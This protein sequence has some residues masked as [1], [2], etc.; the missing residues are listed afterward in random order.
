[1]QKTKLNA[2]QL[3]ELN[4]VLSHNLPCNMVF[5]KHTKKEWKEFFNSVKKFI[6][7]LNKEK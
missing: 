2:K 5:A 4:Y 1:M 7:T 3:N 6:E